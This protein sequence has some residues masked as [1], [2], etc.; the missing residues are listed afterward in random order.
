MLQCIQADAAGRQS[1]GGFASFSESWDSL[2]AGA[3]RYPPL[4]PRDK[5]ASIEQLLNEIERECGGQEYKSVAPRDFSQALSQDDHD[6]GPPGARLTAKSNLK[7]T[8]TGHVSR[9]N[10]DILTPPD[11]TDTFP[12]TSFPSTP[13]PALSQAPPIPTSR[14]PQPLSIPQKLRYHHYESLSPTLPTLPT[15]PALPALPGEDADTYVYM[16]PRDSFNRSN[17]VP[18]TAHRRYPNYGLGQT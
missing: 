17:S 9:D 1:H 11:S 4:K 13:T 2:N 8:Q 14:R 3:A 7:S 6:S 10:Y 12:S 5:N 16:A 15:L 18:E